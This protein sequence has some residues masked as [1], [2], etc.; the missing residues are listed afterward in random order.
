[1]ALPD[2][3]ALR[4]KVDVGSDGVN[5]VSYWTRSWHRW[6]V[7][8]GAGEFY[9][10]GKPITLVTP[11]GGRHEYR[12]RLRAVTSSGS[13]VTVNDLSLES[14]LKGVVPLEIPAS[15]SPDAVRA[16][17]VAARTYAAYE[18]RHPQSKAYQLCDTTSCQVYGGFSAEYAASNRAV[19]A[20]AHKILLSGGEPAF[21]QFA[22]S[23]GG[24]TSA[25]SVPYLPAKKDPYDGWSGNPMHT[26]TQKIN[27]ALVERTWPAIGNLTKIAVTSRDGNGDWGGRVRSI[28][29]TG[30]AGKVVVS[31][32]TFRS[33]LA[34]RSTWVTFKVAAR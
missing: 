1:V 10:A 11:G 25:G 26:W 20:T 28:T 34:L 23:S 18:R 17:A 30:S 2:N 7:L 6:K 22:S 8:K 14:Y 3:G 5:R 29:L 15:W 9:A 32:D 33:L 21:T 12:G 19:D 31:G 16:Q 27:D 13:R 4:W 24:W